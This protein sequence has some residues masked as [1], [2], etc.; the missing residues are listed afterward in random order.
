[1]A[2]GSWVRQAISAIAPGSHLL[3]N[4]RAK[5]RVPVRSPGGRPLDARRN[6]LDDLFRGFHEV[7]VHVVRLVIP[8]DVHIVPLLEGNMLSG[9]K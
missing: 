2:T 6:A 4:W 3:A 7:V 8:N 9:K 1:M 5:V